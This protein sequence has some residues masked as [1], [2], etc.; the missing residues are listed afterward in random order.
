MKLSKLFKKCFVAC[1]SS[2]G[3]PGGVVEYPNTRNKPSNIPN[4]IQNS[5]KYQIKKNKVYF[6]PKIGREGILNTHF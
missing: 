3:R 1:F 4:I 5:C 6:I 2:Q